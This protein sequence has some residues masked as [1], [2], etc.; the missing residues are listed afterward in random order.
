[1]LNL[2]HGWQPGL[3]QGNSN[4]HGFNFNPVLH[5]F[6]ILFSF[7]RVEE[8]EKR[9]ISSD[10]FFYPLVFITLNVQWWFRTWVWPGRPVILLALRKG[11]SLIPIAVSVRTW[12]SNS[13]CF[14]H[15]SNSASKSWNLSS[16]NSVCFPL[17]L[18]YNL[19]NHC[20][21][22]NFYIAIT[23]YSQSLDIE[24]IWII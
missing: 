14:S 18:R 6:L 9:A 22:S 2:R 3:F 13:F 23:N 15:F 1:M 21:W 7:R 19:S 17:M 12:G 10:L 4:M 5:Y 16:W 20:W 8:R 24:V 11:G